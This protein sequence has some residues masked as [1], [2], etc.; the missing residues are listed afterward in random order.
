MM[1]YEYLTGSPIAL[2]KVWKTTIIHSFMES[3]TVSGCKKKIGCI[4]NY[5]GYNIKLGNELVK[6]D[7]LCRV[8]AESSSW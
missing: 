4:K 7:D 8:N 5:I 3:F 2:F 6:L 1:S